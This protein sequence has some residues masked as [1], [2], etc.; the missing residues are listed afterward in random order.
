MVD[1]GPVAAAALDPSTPE[2]RLNSAAAVVGPVTISSSL[3]P[4]LSG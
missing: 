4:T 3:R 2:R 1:S